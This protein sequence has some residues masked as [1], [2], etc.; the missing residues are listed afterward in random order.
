M[1]TFFGLFEK[2]F[3]PNLTSEI[4]AKNGNF[5]VG[6]LPQFDQSSPH[7]EAPRAMGHYFFT[8]DLPLLAHAIISGAAV[9]ARGVPAETKS[10]SQEKSG[11][12]KSIFVGHFAKVRKSPLFG[13]K[14]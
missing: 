6:R 7:T 8:V 1:E 12:K 10:G 9:R 13:Q 4:E 3:G 2:F 14:C 5:E 11:K